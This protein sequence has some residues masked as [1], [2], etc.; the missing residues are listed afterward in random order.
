MI[1]DKTLFFKT[2]KS[3]TPSCVP[4]SASVF[5]EAMPRQVRLRSTSYDRTRRRDKTVRYIEAPISIIDNHLDNP[6]RF[7]CQY[8]FL[9]LSVRRIMDIGK[10]FYR[11]PQRC[12]SRRA[13]ESRRQVF[14]AYK[15]S[16]LKNWDK[17][18]FSF[19][20]A[21]LPNTVNGVEGHRSG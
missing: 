14:R 10:V 8:W 15:C 16:L 2:D 3:I 1:I 5:A 18:P 12:K 6:S 13:S 11:L 19:S 17:E 7:Y 4:A 9:L 20:N 21:I